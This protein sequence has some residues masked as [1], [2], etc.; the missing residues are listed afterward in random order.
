[1]ME[2][3]L[4]AGE[5]SSF[6]DAQLRIIA[7]ASARL[8]PTEGG[9]RNDSDHFDCG[10]LTQKPAAHF[11]GRVLCEAIHFEQNTMFDR[12][13]QTKFE[14]FFHRCGK[15]RESVRAGFAKAVRMN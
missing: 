4:M 3:L 2:I 14:V 11:C 5:S 13:S 6:P 12:T 9:F 8:S 10:A 15:D 1:M 7:C